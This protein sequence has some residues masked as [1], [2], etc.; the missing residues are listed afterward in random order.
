MD[1]HADINLAKIQMADGY[2][3]MLKWCF[4]HRDTKCLGSM[5]HK[6]TIFNVNHLNDKNMICNHTTKYTNTF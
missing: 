4:S 6:I 5:R 1:H 2:I 3:L